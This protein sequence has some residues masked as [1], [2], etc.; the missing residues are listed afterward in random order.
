M[1]VLRG[2]RPQNDREPVPEA[3]TPDFDRPPDEL[4]GDPLAVKEWARVVPML[5][6]CGVVSNAERS[7]LIALCTEWSRYLEAGANI[8]QLGMLIKGKD[9]WPVR[10]PFIRIENDCLKHCQRL[11]TELGLTPSSRT[12]LTT[13]P[14]ATARPASKWGNDL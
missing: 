11:W 2:K 14:E 10:N 3:A 9:G 7:A 4:A 8:R 6:V 5:R 1:R 13:L 12:R